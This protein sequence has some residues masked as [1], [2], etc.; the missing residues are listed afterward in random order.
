MAASRTGRNR[1]LWAH[2]HLDTR[3]R[4]PLLAG[5]RRALWLR[6]RTRDEAPPRLLLRPGADQP[7]LPRAG[8]LTGG[9]AD[10]LDRR[11]AAGQAPPAGGP[12]HPHRPAATS[13]APRGAHTP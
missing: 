1:V 13:P 8:P 11:R 9:G 6:H 2:A 4:H 10:L 3:I 5:A 7:D 12:A